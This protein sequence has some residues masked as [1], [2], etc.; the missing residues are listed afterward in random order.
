MDPLLLSCAAY[1]IKSLSYSFLTPSSGTF[2][3]SAKI[4]L[5]FEIFF[6]KTLGGKKVLPCARVTTNRRLIV[7]LMTFVNALL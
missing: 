5:N 3:L 2:I 7:E 1:V 4:C 6:G